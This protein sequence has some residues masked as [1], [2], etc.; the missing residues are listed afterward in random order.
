MINHRDNPVEWAMLAY[1]LND[2]REHLESLIKEMSEAD[3]FTDEDFATALGHVFA[4][5]NRSWNTRNI[6]TAELNAEQMDVLS[7]FPTDLIPIG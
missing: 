3:D 5:L 6:S 4:H 2:A 7:Q 1:E